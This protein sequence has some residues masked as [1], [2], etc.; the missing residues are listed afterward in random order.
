[1]KKVMIYPS[2]FVR[3]IFI[4]DCF[5]KDHESDPSPFHVLAHQY[6]A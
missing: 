1:M 6:L 4:T 3:K 2:P 5:M